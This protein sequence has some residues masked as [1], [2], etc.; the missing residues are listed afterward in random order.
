MDLMTQ[1]KRN[2]KVSLVQND[3]PNCFC[4]YF[5][6]LKVVFI[7]A[8]LYSYIDRF[9]VAALKNKISSNFI[10]NNNCKKAPCIA[11]VVYT[12]AY[13]LFWLAYLNINLNRLCVGTYCSQNIIHFLYWAWTCSF[14]RNWKT[15]CLYCPGYTQYCCWPVDLTSIFQKHSAMDE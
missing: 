7:F 1:Q 3:K 9:D 10:Y 8:Y 12:D 13:T 15:C 14:G 6:A 5:S 11:V 2:N 4:N